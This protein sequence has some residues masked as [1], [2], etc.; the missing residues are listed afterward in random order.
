MKKSSGNLQDPISKKFFRL[1]S[2][3]W[4]SSEGV[5]ASLSLVGLSIINLGTV[6]VEV[7]SNF[8]NNTFFTALEKVNMLP[9]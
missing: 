4:L 2:V 3:Y 5:F 6:Y 8:W 1:L 9:S 7:K